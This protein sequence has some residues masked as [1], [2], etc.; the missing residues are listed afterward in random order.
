M[1]SSCFKKRQQAVDSPN[2]LNEY[3]FGF[4]DTL[5]QNENGEI[6][7]TKRKVGFNYVTPEMFGAVGDGITDDTDAI[8]SAFDTGNTVVFGSK[9]YYVRSERGNNYTTSWYKGGVFPHDN[10]LIIL[11][12]ATLTT[13]TPLNMGSYSILNIQG[14]SNVIILGGRIVGVDSGTHDRGYGICI[15]NYEDNTSGTTVF[16]R[17]ENILIYGVNI[18]TCAGDSIILTKSPSTDSN[19]NSNHVPYNITIRKCVLH[20]NRR[21]GISIQSGIKIVLDDCIMYNIGGKSPETGIDIESETTTENSGRLQDITISNCHIY[22]TASS[23]IVIGP[24]QTVANRWTPAKTVRIYR[25]NLSTVNIANGQDIII[26]DCSIH[27]LTISDN[28]TVRTTNTTFNCQSSQYKYPLHIMCS[29][30]V[31]TNCT[32]NYDFSDSSQDIHAIVRC[33]NDFDTNLDFDYG[34]ITFNGCTFNESFHST[35]ST[36]Q[37]M[38]V[39]GFDTSGIRSRIKSVIFNGCVGTFGNRTLFFTSG[40][41]PKYPAQ[42]VSI[43]NSSFNFTRTGTENFIK[44]GS[45]ILPNTYSVDVQG[46]VI[47]APGFTRLLYSDLTGSKGISLRIS[48]SDI[49]VGSGLFY[50]NNTELSGSAI[51]TGNYI[52]GSVLQGGSFGNMKTLVADNLVEE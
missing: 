44:V 13:S 50:N 2:T 51:I 32:F 5:I 34:C 47:N 9:T 38:Y 1:K 31:F 8:Q 49:Y 22:N 29:S 20:D 42:G 10:Q 15:T 23:S 45:S 37:S 19:F 14:K 16:K 17:S 41:S 24:H 39:V 43:K 46:S 11:G 21:Q 25:C 52:T 26:D 40:S 48:N 4:I 33:G 3:S 6:T 28:S 30:P 36:P 7:A 35:S 18:S 27:R 12:S